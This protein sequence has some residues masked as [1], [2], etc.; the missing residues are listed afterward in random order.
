MFRKYCLWGC[1]FFFLFI[2]N[3]FALTSGNY[4]Y[5]VLEDNMA[6]LQEL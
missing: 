1:V 5:E 2:G 4:S 3:V 6:L